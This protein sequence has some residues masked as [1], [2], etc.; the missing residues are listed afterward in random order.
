[1]FFWRV[2]SSCGSAECR[3]VEETG[4]RP[5]VK[6]CIHDKWRRIRKPRRAP[7]TWR[8]CLAPP[9]WA[10]I[11]YKE[12]TIDSATSPSRPAAF[13]TAAVGCG[14][15]GNVQRS[16]QDEEGA[17]IERAQA[18]V[19]EQM[20]RAFCTFCWSQVNTSSRQMARA[21]SHAKLYFFAARLPRPRFSGSGSGAAAAAAASGSGSG[22]AS[23]ISSS[24]CLTAS[25]AAGTALPPP[26]AT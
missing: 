2:L 4:A 5:A 13:V 22:A 17:G 3:G 7:T 9:C 6:C 14:G 16:V 24:S 20:E 19:L 8:S 15:P 23:G 25:S 21:L 10:P 18:S 12:T 26:F 11:D 1:M